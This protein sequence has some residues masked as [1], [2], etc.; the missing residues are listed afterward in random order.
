MY[1]PASSLPRRESQLTEN[2]G[3]K[4]RLTE[5]VDDL[6]MA[7]ML[8]TLHDR[9]R[10][11]LTILAYHRVTPLEGDG[12][13]LD[14]ELV[15]ATPD[16]FDWQMKH[17]REHMQPVSLRQVIEHID[18]VRPLPPD[19]VAVT[20]DDG[21]AD[22]YR[23]AF[24]SLRRHGIPATVFVITGNVESGEPFWF[25][26]A[27]YLMARL[28]PGTLR[29]D[30]LDEALPRGA[31]TAERRLS[32]RFLHDA[33]KAVTNVRRTQV[34]RQWASDYPGGFDH[35]AAEV[36]WPMTWEQIREMAEAGI[37]FG[38]HTV[39]HPNL[40]QLS[41]ASLLWEL[42]ESRR[43]L[44]QKLQRQ[45]ESFA[46][47]FGTRHAYDMNVVA[48][49]KEAG[50]RLAASYLPGVNWADALEPLELRRIGVELST[51]ASQFRVRTA[52]PAWLG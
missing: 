11:V 41:S 6:G 14:T 29:M 23:Y 2:K 46:Y 5:L 25:E 47:P 42:T 16:V 13:P 4:L 9:G 22:V 44:E 34:F 52:L 10:D 49:V 45:V 50:F 40:V 26:H 30:E 48:S 8:K 17:L 1:N 32:L 3:K 24:P 28:A 39:T 36:G 43:V 15:S 51:T 37:E 35:A 21:F 7:P 38:S 27:A 33:L 18:G 20:F 12:R 19:A 31:G